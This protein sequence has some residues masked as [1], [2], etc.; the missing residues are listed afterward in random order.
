MA[1]VIE[2]SGN[3]SS[4]SAQK[5]LIGDTLIGYPIGEIKLEVQIIAN[6]F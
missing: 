1:N 5:I 2:V 4:N 6:N 3:T